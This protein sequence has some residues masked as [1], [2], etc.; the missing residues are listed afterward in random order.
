MHPC[1]VAVSWLNSRYRRLDSSGFTVTATGGHALSTLSASEARPARWAPGTSLLKFRAA[2]A[3]PP[4]GPGEKTPGHGTWGAAAH[5]QFQA[6]LPMSL[7][8]RVTA[9]AGRRWACQWAARAD[10]GPK[11]TG[12]ASS[13]LGRMLL[14]T[15][16]CTVAAVPRLA[17]ACHCRRALTVGCYADCGRVTQCPLSEVP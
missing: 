10:A 5:S 12:T 2:A 14:T 3:A 1:A 4:A 8:L 13:P 9:P 16:A 11:A 6:P 17:A 7:P 15:V